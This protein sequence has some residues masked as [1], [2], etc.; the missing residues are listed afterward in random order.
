MPGLDQHMALLGELQR[1]GD[2][3]AQDLDHLLLIGQHQ[4]QLG[5]VAEQQI[6]RRVG[7]QGAQGAAQRGEDAVHA[8]LHRLHI[9]LAGLH[10]GQVQ[11]V[12]DHVQ[13]ALGRFADVLHLSLL[14]RVQVAVHAVHQQAG[15][16]QDRVQRC[17]ELMAHVGQEARL[18]IAHAAQLLGFLFQ[19]G[20]QGHHAAVGFFQL[21]VQS[22]RFGLAVLQIIQAFDD[23]AVLILQ[24]GDGVCARMAR[25]QLRDGLLGLACEPQQRALGQ[26]LRQAHH[27]APGS[28]L[29]VEL[30]HQA[31]RARQALASARRKDLAPLQHVVQI[32]DAGPIIGDH[33]HEGV[34]WRI[35]I[36][37]EL[38]PGL[39]CIGEGI[40]GD[41]GDGGGH[42]CLA[43]AVQSQDLGRL[44]GVQARGD[45]VLRGHEVHGAQA[46]VFGGRAGHGRPVPHTT[47]VASSRPRLKSLYRAPA[48]SMG[49]RHS[50]GV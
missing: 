25:K 45:H 14:L 11:Q 20:V 8:E 1:I 13:Q 15:Q 6:H 12:V 29:D 28:A 47:T 36:D 18:G 24:G 17:A 23:L 5:R 48:I 21:Q 39:A 43:L 7:E 30:V 37:D 33:H 22:C 2:E 34:G 10:L 41:L 35:A 42:A 46:D 26:A 27:G 50:S 9:H 4:R 31:T 16:G 38:G 32:V 49:W 3:V 44:S 19:F 40:A